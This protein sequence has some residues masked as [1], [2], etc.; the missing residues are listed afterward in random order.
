MKYKLQVPEPPEHGKII[1]QDGKNK[2]LQVYKDFQ[3]GELKRLRKTYR[4]LA[5]DPQYHMPYNWNRRTELLEN[6]GTFLGFAENQNTGETRLYRANFCKERLCP[7]C[8]RNNA[9]YGFHMLSAVENATREYVKMH[10]VDG[11]TKL[12]SVF[13]TLTLPN[14][15]G[16]DLYAELRLFL[17]AF[18]L[19][20]RRKKMKPLQKYGGYWKIE[21]TFNSKTKLFNLHLHELLFTDNEYFH[22]G[23]ITTRELSKLW[24]NCVNSAR[25]KIETE[26]REKQKRLKAE[27]LKWKR[28]LSEIV[29]DNWLEERVKE[30]ESDPDGGSGWKY[31]ERLKAEEQYDKIVDEKYKD[32]TLKYADLLRQQRD[33]QMLTDSVDHGFFDRTYSD[34]VVDIRAGGCDS[35]GKLVAELTKYISKPLTKM[36]ETD[37]DAKTFVY[38]VNRALFHQHTNGY[39][40]TAR[41]L[42][43][44][45][46][47][48]EKKQEKAEAEK[49]ADQYIISF[50]KQHPDATVEDVA[51]QFGTTP[52]HAAELKAKAPNVTEDDNAAAWML[53]VYRWKHGN[54]EV[55]TLEKE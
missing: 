34:L 13:M 35:D 16:E 21:V 28:Q 31:W 32:D 54:Y 43:T 23:Y 15:R 50:F 29:G 25:E 49:E 45:I 30:I 46:N 38:W 48:D 4:D 1:A 12:R 40:G 36:T 7:I 3:N 14:C 24:S 39:F 8:M 27:T 44:Q 52:E 42:Q 11:E 55:D 33:N 9:M 10:A 6:C 26:A 17:K 22:S 47:A 41:K 37:D 53:Y 5:A 2:T 20:R 51:K 19:L 18:L